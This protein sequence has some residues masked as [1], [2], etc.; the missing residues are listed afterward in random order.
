VAARVA[1]VNSRVRS[2]QAAIQRLRL[3]YR[4]AKKVADI[5][6]IENEMAGREADLESLQAQQ[7]ALTAET[8]TASVTLYLLTAHPR[9]IPKPVHH[10]SGFVGGL[11]NGWDALVRTA[12]WAATVLGAIIPF[13]VL[14]LAVAVGTRIVWVRLR[15]MRTNVAPSD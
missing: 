5:I 4:Q 10:R 9:A 15:P 1:D 12:S 13:A 14:L 11:E 7:R 6:A 3:L 8:A 2:E